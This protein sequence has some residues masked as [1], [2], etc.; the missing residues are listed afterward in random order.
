MQDLRLPQLSMLTGIKRHTLNARVKTNLPSQEISKNKA[1]QVLLNQLQTKKII[2]DIITEDQSIILYIGNLKGGVGKTT[3]SYLLSNATSML[4]IK[5]CVLDLDIQANLTSQYLDID[6]EQSVFLDIIK[7]KQTLDSATISI[8]EYLSIIPSSLKN[9]LIEKELSMQSSKHLLNWINDLC[10]KELKQKYNVIII[11]TPPSLTTLNS[12]FC[13]A[14]SDNDRIVIPVCAEE[15]SAMG[16]KM[17]L[18][19]VMDIRQSY[20]V[21]ED[22]NISIVMNKFFQTQKNNLQLLG[23]MS[24]EYEGLLSEIIFRDNAQIREMMN[25]KTPLNAIKNGKEIYLML[26]ALL[27]EFKILKDKVN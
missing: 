14:L 10:I 22:L 13:L 19:D 2:N 26:S 5:T 16:V 21:I 6:A 20:N 23:K 24:N 11:D 9:S 7:G 3:L 1:N 8:N 27:K 17:F 15:F 18:G 4:G 25:N 12:V